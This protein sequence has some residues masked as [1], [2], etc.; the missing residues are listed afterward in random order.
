MTSLFLTHFL[1]SEGTSTSD[2]GVVLY[3]MVYTNQDGRSTALDKL[4]K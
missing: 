4:L 3:E 2:G 1:V